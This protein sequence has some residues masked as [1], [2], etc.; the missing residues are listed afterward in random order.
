MEDWRREEGLDLEQV[1]L[2]QPKKTGHLGFESSQG[3]RWKTEPGYYQLRGQSGLGSWTLLH[4]HL[5]R[6]L[7][8]SLP[9]A[10]RQ[11]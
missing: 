4:S 9:Q 1:P 5:V 10:N 7:Y 2:G 3:F 11:A 6:G 8:L